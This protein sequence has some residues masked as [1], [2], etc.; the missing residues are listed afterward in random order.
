LRSPPRQAERMI[1]FW[2]FLEILAM[3]RRGAQARSPPPPHCCLPPP[4]TWHKLTS[5]AHTNCGGG[6]S[7]ARF[8][9]LVS[10]PCPADC[11][12][13]RRH[14]TAANHHPPIRSAPIPFPSPAKP[15]RLAVASP[16]GRSAARPE[17]K[18]K[19]QRPQQARRQTAAWL[20]SAATGP[21]HHQHRPSGPSQ[22]GAPSAWRQVTT[23]AHRRRRD[24]I[25]RIDR[26]A[27][28]G[29][30]TGFVA[31]GSRQRR[32]IRARGVGR[33]RAASTGADSIRHRR[34]LL[35]RP[36]AESGRA[37]RRVQQSGTMQTGRPGTRQTG[38]FVCAP[39]GRCAAPESS[40][41]RRRRRRW[42]A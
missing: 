3:R 27:P 20:R 37:R 14:N 26:L 23:S 38:V 30:Q 33:S 31:V 8:I 15:D 19:S 1:S 29:P 35:F 28:H 32:A 12:A 22:G 11:A 4:Q 18:R 7:F 21:P 5:L 42:T 10:R 41:G 17:S 34:L 2:Q 39:P 25:D 13:A 36:A 40:A 24:C 6:A 16:P 9:S